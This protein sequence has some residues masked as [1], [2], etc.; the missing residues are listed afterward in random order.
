[1]NNNSTLKPHFGQVTTVSELGTLLRAFRKSHGLTLE[2][3]SGLTNVSMRFLSELERGKETAEIGKTLATLYKLGLDIII[4][5][6]TYRYHHE[7]DLQ[8]D[9]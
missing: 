5:P 4:Q 3:V 1:M 6:R 8:A 9:E 7:K 2:K